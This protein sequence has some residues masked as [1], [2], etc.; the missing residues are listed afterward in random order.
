M[1]AQNKSATPPERVDGDKRLFVV[2]LIIFI[3]TCVVVIVVNNSGGNL[4]RTG[5]VTA[6]PAQQITLVPEVIANLTQ[7]PDSQTLG[8]EFS[9]KI[10][11]LREAIADCPDYSPARRE[12]MNQHIAWLL[13]TSTL[14]RDMV[15]ALGSDPFERLVF[16]M[17]T[18]T[19]AE[20]G[21]HDQSP[22]SCLLNIG[23]ELNMLLES[24]G[25]PGFE[26]FK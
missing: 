21:L 4:Q 23:R 11:D 5:T 7:I 10:V 14:P 24:M 16:G 18:Y 3:V 8:V 13:D 9:G 22:A 20:W 15:I 26:E 19:S 6:T 17:A 2:S 1:K 25:S 12:Q